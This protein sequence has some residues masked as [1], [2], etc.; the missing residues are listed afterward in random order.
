MS[1]R[2]VE[3]NPAQQDVLDVLGSL[4]D[5]RPVFDAGLRHDL[6]IEL[7]DGLAPVVTALDDVDDTE[8]LWVSK[9]ALATVHGC[10]VRFLAED[11]IG[12]AGWSVPTARGTVAHKAIELSVHWRG[13]PTP[14]EL[15]DEAI[16]RLTET[17]TGPTALAAWLQGLSDVE[18]AELRAQ[19]NDHVAKFL[20]CFPPLRARWR[21][22]TEAKLRQSLCGERIVLAGKADLT[23]GMA[24]GTT[25]GKV[26]ID[27]KTGGFAPAHLDDLRFYA[28]VEA[29]RMGVPP[30]RLATYYLDAGR[31]MAEDVTEAMLRST[32]ARVIDGAA[33]MVALR[34]GGAQPVLR[35]G[36]ACR[37][38]PKLAECETGR[39][40]LSQ[41]EA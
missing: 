6:R 39:S 25:A 35:P 16:A 7:E 20:E 3:L 32:T 26:L 24:S 1:E 18:R 4:R 40:H 21:P 38:C 28:L 22:V 13:A 29:M 23:L 31:L 17:A 15:T 5:G 36:P 37:W 9:H 14:M 33:R 27:L 34:H 2:A 41:R 30:R 10:E 19:V 11:A 8:T 12:F